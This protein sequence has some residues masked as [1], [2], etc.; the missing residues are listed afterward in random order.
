[1]DNAAKVKFTFENPLNNVESTLELSAG[2]LLQLMREKI[3]S[4]NPD[5]MDSGNPLKFPPD[6]ATYDARF[7]AEVTTFTH[8][9]AFFLRCA[10]VGGVGLLS[11]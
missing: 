7:D 9:Y 5:E 10:Q 2:G 8:V 6:A 4:L 11:F 1:M 3:P